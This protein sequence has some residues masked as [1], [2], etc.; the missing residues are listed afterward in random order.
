MFS[1][2]GLSLHYFT[3]YFELGIIK[4]KNVCTRVYY[5]RLSTTD[6]LDKFQIRQIRQVS[7]QLIS[8]EET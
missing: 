8:Q 5:T 3:R 7:G 2:F 4:R 6:K 1:I